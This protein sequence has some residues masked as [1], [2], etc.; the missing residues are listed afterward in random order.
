MKLV[1]L[2]AAGCLLS[3]FA[4]AE[5]VPV[6]VELF[7][8]EGC[9]SCP[10][11][12][13]LLSELVRTQPVPGVRV[14]ALSEHVTYWN[15]LGWKDP[16]SSATFTDRQAEY[17]HRFGL[18]SNYTPQ[19]VIDGRA[20]MVGSRRESVLEAI[21]DAA[22]EPKAQ[23]AVTRLGDSKLD[24]TVGAVPAGR[25]PI[26]VYLAIVENDLSSEVGRGENHGR[27]LRHDSVVR[28][29]HRLGQ[30]DASGSF[31]AEARLEASNGWKRPNLEA[32]VFVQRRRDGSVAGVA[33]APA[34]LARE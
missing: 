34:G 24:V 23:V 27:T 21:R 9:S 31:H 30:L 20:E 13:A 10:P 7:T 32:V 14:I 5:P 22:R 17:V 33:V 4:L 1:A 19:M 29:L 25:G 15:D 8:S 18:R 11:A 2:A 16:F 3:T 28:E 12:D 6:V 26:D